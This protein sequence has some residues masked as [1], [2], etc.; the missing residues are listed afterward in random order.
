MAKNPFNPHFTLL[1]CFTLILLIQSQAL[2]LLPSDSNALLLVQRD[3]GLRRPPPRNPCNS[4]GI[5]CE[6]RIVNSS[7]ILRITRFVLESQNLRGK[8]SPA[9]GKLSELKELSLPNN[10][11][12]DQIPP[13]IVD[14]HKL[15]T[16]NLARNRFSGEIPSGLSWLIH[17]RVLDLSSNRFSGDLNFL[18][19]FPN[20]EKLNLADNMFA[21]KVPMSLKSFR[22][23][24]FINMSANCLLEV[25]AQLMNNHLDQLLPSQLQIKSKIPKRYFFAETNQTASSSS[26]AMSPS[27]SPNLNATAPAPDPAPLAGWAHNHKR[28]HKRRITGWVLGFIAGTLTGCFSGLTF[29]LLFK[30][31]VVFFITGRGDYTSLK[32]FSPLIKKPEDLAFLE[33]E[34][35]LESLKVIGRGGCGEVYKA[36]LPGENGKEIAIK[37]ITQPAIDADELTDED[38]KLLTKK[39]RQ[40]KAEIQTVG[41]IRHK[42]LLPLLAHLPRPDCHYLVYEYMR[43]GSLQDYLQDVAEGKRELDWPARYKI[44]L[45]IASGL[46]YLHMNHTP[47]I[48]HRDLKPANVL[49]DDEMEAR[50][51][52]FG[53]AKAVPDAHTHITTSNVAG[54]IGYIAPEYHQTLKF[55]D[56]CDV[57]SFGVLLG[58][59]VMGK[60]P[61]DEFFQRTDEMS[62]VKWLRNV[63]VSGDPKRAIDSKLLGSGFEEQMLLV[64]KIACFCT[65]DN[66]KERP[67]SKDVRGMLSQIKH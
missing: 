39:M 51:A 42:N 60:L 20:L 27:S 47:R 43:N 53:L 44:A 15:E 3:I 24:R 29:S 56:K 62:L 58:A 5:F 14:L 11:L 1:S 49:L 12:V 46:E 26:S 8:L 9:I 30:F 66:P 52:D 25:P 35:G 45:G 37:K 7:Q 18:K 6:Q 17:L 67:N 2:P 41:Q 33:K 48:I 59:L 16:L 57:Y 65:L 21:G 40:V 13:Q 61:S 31:I 38:S 10:H 32:L 34:D 22:N 50:I 19:F 36:V 54:T 64:L 23:L 55:T 28:H 4:A 63:M